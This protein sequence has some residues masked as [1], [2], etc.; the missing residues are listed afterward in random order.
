MKNGLIDLRGK[1]PQGLVDV[2]QRVQTLADQLQLDVLVVGAMA[3]DLVLVHG[4]NARLER[5]TRDIDFAVQLADWSSFHTLTEALINDNFRKS[6]KWSHRFNFNAKDDMTWEIG[7]IPF[8]GVTDPEQNIKWPPDQSIMMSVLGF[9]EAH[10]NALY[11]NIGDDVSSFVMKVVS[12]PAM[13]VL[14][15]I[16]WL[17]R[18]PTIRRK[19]A[20]DLRYLMNTYSKIPQIFD[21]IYEQGFMEAQDWDE[22]KASAMILGADANALIKPNTHEFL[23][24]NLITKPDKLDLL[25]REMVNTSIEIDYDDSELKVFIDVFS[26]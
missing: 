3:R 15:L 18:E 2:Y 24:S 17:E 8:G 20:Q 21:R 25:L 5:G 16:S 4:F 1:L 9:D 11:V 10:E 7:I 13:S 14:K 19:D 6:E 26:K 12:P 22:D 23:S